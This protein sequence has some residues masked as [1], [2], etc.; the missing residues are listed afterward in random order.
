MNWDKRVKRFEV[1]EPGAHTLSGDRASAN[2][3]FA[4]EVELKEFRVF[5]CFVDRVFAG[6]RTIHETH[7]THEIPEMTR[8][9]L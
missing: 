3:G 2:V 8:K 9:V 5:V 7:E 1:F 6:I 4:K